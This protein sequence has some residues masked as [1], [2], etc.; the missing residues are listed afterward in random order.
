MRV[1]W[2]A[3]QF[4]LCLDMNDNWTIQK[5]LKTVLRYSEEKKAWMGVKNGKIVRI[6]WPT[7]RDIISKYEV[8]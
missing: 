8:V 4:D 1:L 6:E 3:G 7:F 2:S 5:D